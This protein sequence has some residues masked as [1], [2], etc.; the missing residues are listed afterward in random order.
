[1]SASHSA[2]SRRLACGVDPIDEF[3]RVEA[4]KVAPLDV[5]NA[6]FRHETAHVPDVDAEVFSYLIDG[7]E[8]GQLHGRSSAGGCGAHAVD[9]HSRSSSAVSNFGSFVSYS[10]FSVG[11]TAV[12]LE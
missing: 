3:S 4:K 11:R 12:T 1:M 9:R 6:S 2:S 7:Q 8:L 5:G 10:G